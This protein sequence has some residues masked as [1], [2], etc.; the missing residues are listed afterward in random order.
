MRWTAEQMRSRIPVWSQKGTVERCS[1]VVTA[2]RV[3]TVRCDEVLFLQD[4][5]NRWHFKGAAAL[6]TAA[7]YPG[8]RPGT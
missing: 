1:V 4:L 6:A 2:P 7:R 3:D 8:T 5:I